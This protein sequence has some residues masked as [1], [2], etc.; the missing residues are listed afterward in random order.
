MKKKHLNPY[1]IR[2]Q[3]Y[4][5]MI[6]LSL[7]FTNLYKINVKNKTMNLYS[8][9]YVLFIRNKKTKNLR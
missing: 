2:I 6:D 8:T 7:V 5:Y 4:I 3:I 1:L 9:F